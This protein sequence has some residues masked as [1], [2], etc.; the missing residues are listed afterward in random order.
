MAT[1]NRLGRAFS[2][3]TSSNNIG[4]T[5]TMLRAYRTIQRLPSI[6]VRAHPLP[7]NSPGCSRCFNHRVAD[8]A[9]IVMYFRLVFFHFK[10]CLQP[11]KELTVADWALLKPQTTKTR[12]FTS[13]QPLYISTQILTA[14]YPKRGCY[15][16]R[17]KLCLPA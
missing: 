5:I 2:S 6:A 12:V 4:I 3:S 17:H 13:L 14:L 1:K 9:I 8:A 10:A 7:P 11:P 15:P 16:R